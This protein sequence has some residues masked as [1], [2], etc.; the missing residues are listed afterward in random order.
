MLGTNGVR[1]GGVPEF[2][3]HPVNNIQV[4][5]RRLDHHDVRPLLNISAT[6]R[7]R[8]VTITCVHLIAAPVRQIWGVD[9]AASRKGPNKCRSEFRGVS[10]NRCLAETQLVHVFCESPEPGHP[11][12][13]L[14]ATISAPASTWLAAL[15]AS[16][17][18]VGSFRIVAPFL[19]CWTIPQCPCS[20]YSQRQ[21]SVI[22]SNSGNSYL[23]QPH[24]ALHPPRSPRKR[25][26]PWH[27]SSPEF[28]TTRLLE[29]PTRAPWRHHGSVHHLKAGKPQAWPR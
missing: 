24:R 22:T 8:L 21:T 26:T 14:G 13:S 7:I 15:R 18:R 5:Q 2:C 12:I 3:F 27:P 28:Q 20:M 10:H 17:F 19:P 25:P 1:S 9:S 29:P 6:S 11:I 16:N 4:S 23:K